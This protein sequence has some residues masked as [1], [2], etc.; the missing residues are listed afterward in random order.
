MNSNNDGRSTMKV[1]A[2]NFRAKRKALRL[3]QK[4]ARRTNRG[5]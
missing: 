2:V 4:S 5:S 1:S 3:T